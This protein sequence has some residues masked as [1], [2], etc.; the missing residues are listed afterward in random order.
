MDVLSVAWLGG[1]YC[2][3]LDGAI[4][5]RGS[6]ALSI[7][8]FSGAGGTAT[9]CRKQ[10]RRQE[11]EDVVPAPLLLLHLARLGSDGAYLLCPLTPP[12]GDA[13]IEAGFSARCTAQVRTS[14]ECV[15]SMVEGPA[16]L[17]GTEFRDAVP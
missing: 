17:V 5:P 9:K 2:V 1:R 15:E 12:K 11:N 10:R 13:V 14:G 4:M 8:T 3:P 7:D 16:K 6:K